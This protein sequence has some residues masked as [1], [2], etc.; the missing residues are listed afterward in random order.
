MALTL[1]L[2]KHRLPHLRSPQRLGAAAGQYALPGKPFRLSLMRLQRGSIRNEHGMDGKSIRE[3]APWGGG[4]HQGA[5]GGTR[6]GGG[7]QGRR[8][9]SPKSEETEAACRDGGRVALSAQ[10]LA[11]C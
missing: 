11:M 2:N 7:H 4:G 3:P 8:G 9:T 5:A 10:V 6:D 1:L